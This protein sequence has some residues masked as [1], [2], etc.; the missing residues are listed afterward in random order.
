MARVYNVYNGDTKVADG[1]SE[2][3][4]KVTDLT[5]ETKYTFKV[6]AVEDGQ[7]S[8]GATL[9]V[10]TPKAEP[11]KVTTITPSQKTMTIKVGDA[12]RAVTFEVAPENATDKTFTVTSDNE[13][14]A[15]WVDGKVH[16]VAEGS[17]NII[18]TANDGS[19]VTGTVA[20]TVNPAEG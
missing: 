6:T 3:T 9:D 20:V 8:A 1:I 4:F 5:P 2:T 19:G 18:A 14:I 7:E 15:T 16:P 12:D 10:T 17:A 11:V 13:A